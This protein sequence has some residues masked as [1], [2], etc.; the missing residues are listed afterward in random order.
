MSGDR[1]QC[2]LPRG[3]ANTCQVRISNGPQVKLLTCRLTVGDQASPKQ[4]FLADG[5]LFEDAQL[6]HRGQM[7]VGSRFGGLQQMSQFS[8]PQRAACSGQLIEQTEHHF[9]RFQQYGA[10]GGLFVILF[11][12]VTS[13]R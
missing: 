2:R 5:I 11:Q 4:V 6:T 1:Q 12:E 10:G 9:H 8:H 13:S 7:P 3:V